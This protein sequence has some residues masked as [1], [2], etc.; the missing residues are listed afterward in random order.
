LRR[1]SL[2]V[3]SVRIDQARSRVT[4]SGPPGRRDHLR[5]DACWLFHLSMDFF[6]NTQPPFSSRHGIRRSAA[7]T[8]SVD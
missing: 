5:R 2:F 8:L 6:E 7:I 4:M 1:L 3:N